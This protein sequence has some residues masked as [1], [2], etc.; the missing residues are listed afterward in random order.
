MQNQQKTVTI[1]HA[2]DWM[3]Y[4]MLKSPGVFSF[5]MSMFPKIH[6]PMALRRFEVETGEAEAAGAGAG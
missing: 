4:Y 6:N 5:K 3:V 2:H 1:T